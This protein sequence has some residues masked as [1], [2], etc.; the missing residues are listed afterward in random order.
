MHQTVRSFEWLVF[1]D[2]SLAEGEAEFLTRTV[3]EALSWRIV[4]VSLKGGKEDAAIWARS[5]GTVPEGHRVVTTRMDSDDALHPVFLET[6]GEIATTV[7]TPSVVDLV[8]GAY[9]DASAGIPL[10]RPYRGS[11]FQS[12]VDVV[13]PESRIVTV[14]SHPHPELPQSFPYTP[15]STR[16]PM[17]FVSV[18]GGNIANR[19]YGRP[20]KPEVVPAHLQEA[21]GVRRTTAIER[22]TYG[23]RIAIRYSRRF[24]DP[25]EVVPA[26]RMLAGHLVTLHPAK[27]EVRPADHTRHS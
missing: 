13:G 27:A 17:W 12:L 20:R 6:V 2:P 7:P 16:H 15:V 24:M 23:L 14:M 9:V 22:W 3:G 4:P 26:A 5:L 25:V 11:P 18:H 8:C 10:T 21:L 1:V 19:A